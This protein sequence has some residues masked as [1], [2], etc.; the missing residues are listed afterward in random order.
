MAVVHCSGTSVV[1]ASGTDPAVSLN[2]S[3]RIPVVQLLGALAGSRHAGCKDSPSVD[4]TPLNGESSDME[5]NDFLNTVPDWGT[6]NRSNFKAVKTAPDAES[7]RFTFPV[8]EISATPKGCV[9]GS[10]FDELLSTL[11]YSCI[12]SKGDLQS[13]STDSNPCSGGVLWAMENFPTVATVQE[14]G[15]CALGNLARD[16]HE[17]QARI[18]EIGGVESVISAMQAHRIVA[19]VQIGACRALSEFAE[20]PDGRAAITNAGGVEAVVSCLREHMLVANVALE[21]CAVLRKMV[22]DSVE[23]IARIK[24]S[25]GAQAIVRA[26]AAFSSV[27]QLQQHG[28]KLL[29]ILSAGG[30]AD[31][32]T[33]LGGIDVLAEASRNHSTDE[34]VQAEVASALQSLVFSSAAASRRA[35][36]IRDAGN[37]PLGAKSLLP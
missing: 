3:L 9:F 36:E 1:R 4:G 31:A 23:V 25:E 29:G 7:S 16:C 21:A 17:A 28:C 34:F 26:M 37:W 24:T 32:V 27:G 19:N 8:Q 6:Q 15:C 35:H 18:L 5:D 30:L 11:D 13:D 20:N 10:E 22:Q 14:L 33:N 12:S 2:L